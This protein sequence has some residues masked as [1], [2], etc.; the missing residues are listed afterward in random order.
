MIDFTHFPN[1]E[2]RNIILRRMNYND[3]ND[4]FEMRND[5]KMIEYTDS[6]LDR[7]TI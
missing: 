5:P 1:L 3:I 4:L 6:K 2:T 7:T